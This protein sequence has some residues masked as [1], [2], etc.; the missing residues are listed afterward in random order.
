MNNLKATLNK[1][2]VIKDALHNDI[3]QSAQRADQQHNY[4]LDQV[5]DLKEQLAFQESKAFEDQVVDKYHTIPLRKLKAIFPCKAGFYELKAQLPPSFKSTSIESST[6]RVVVYLVFLKEI[7][8][9]NRIE[10]SGICEE[11]DAESNKG[12]AKTDFSDE[13]SSS[14]L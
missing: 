10:N 7:E 13:I 9:Y 1:E 6:P 11:A 3:T 8:T 14:P 12:L 2:M 5:Q 4:F